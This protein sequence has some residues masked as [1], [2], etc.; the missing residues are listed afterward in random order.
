MRRSGCIHWV[1]S[2]WKS[3]GLSSGWGVGRKVTAV[4]SVTNRQADREQSA[5]RVRLRSPCADHTGHV[6]GTRMGVFPA[7]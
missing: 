6:S 3:A 2:M 5:V 7:V 4:S 1:D